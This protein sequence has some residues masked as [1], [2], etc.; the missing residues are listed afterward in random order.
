MKVKIIND[1]IKGFLT[2]SS[3]DSYTQA[4]KL[5]TQ[6]FG[7][8]HHVSN[9]Y[10]A[11]LKKWPWI[12][13]G[14][15]TDL[16]TFSDFL[17]QC[18]RKLWKPAMSQ[19]TEQSQSPA[20]ESVLSVCH[21]CPECLPLM[22]QPRMTNSLIILA[23][24]QHKDSLWI[25]G[26]GDDPCTVKTRFG[27]GIIGPVT[28]PQENLENEEDYEIFTYNRIIS[29]EIPQMSSSFQTCIVKKIKSPHQVKK[30][31]WNGFSRGRL[32]SVVIVARRSELR[33]ALLV[34]TEEP[35]RSLINVVEHYSDFQRAWFPESMSMRLFV[36][37]M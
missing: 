16:H 8:P 6:R 5:L 32:H 9:V 28:S 13:E 4:K 12:K 22:K 15:S 24:F 23:W 25:L 14:Q 10:K 11:Q 3:S 2:I 35:N 31:V 33:D 20:V 18:I 34:N 36:F 26:S 19:G 1:I 21:W 30:N 27:W 37:S 29:R 7:D 17:I